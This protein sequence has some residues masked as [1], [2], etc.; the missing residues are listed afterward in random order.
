MATDP[1]YLAGDGVRLLPVAAGSADR[2]R[3]GEVPA[4][5]V[6]GRGWPHAETAATLDFLDAGGQVWLVVDGT[7]AVVGEIGTKEAAEAGVVEI[8][9]ALAGPHRGR[10]LGSRAVAALVAR[11]DERRDVTQVLARVAPGNEPSRRLLE[12]LGFALV[13]GADPGDECHYRRTSVDAAVTDLRW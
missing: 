6:A 12:R 7:G 4:G 1:P 8:G 11:L 10:G 9:Y 2:L 5:H 13:P 3:R